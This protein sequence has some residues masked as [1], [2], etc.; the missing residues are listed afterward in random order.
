MTILVLGGRGKTASHLASFL[1]A[2][3]VPF[4]LA[5]SSPS[6]ASPYALTHFNWLDEATYENPFME[7]SS[8]SLNQITAVYLVA[9][10]IKDIVPPMIKF[11]DVARSK[12][13][14][15]FVLL[16]AS[17]IGKGDHSM[18]KAHAYLDSF[19]D[20][21]YVALR[22][23]WFMGLT[24]FPLTSRPSFTDSFSENLLEDPHLGWIKAESKIYSATGNGK[25]PFI[26]AYDIAQVAF[27]V[28]AKWKPQKAEYFV[29]GQ[30]LL[31]YS[32]VCQTKLLSILNRVNQ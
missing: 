30:D 11:I 25:I 8:G 7:A 15:R 29:L 28:L 21:E 17:N 19:G 32:E 3:D 26:S 9:P 18:G 1:H 12:G 13:V 31:S 14:K 5:T 10:P 23:T 16:S 2:A 20:V 24:A 6:H 4:L 22:P 27:H